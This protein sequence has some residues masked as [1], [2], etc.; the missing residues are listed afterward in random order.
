MIELAQVSVAGF[1]LLMI[2]S[3]GFHY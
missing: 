2:L 3:F 1:L